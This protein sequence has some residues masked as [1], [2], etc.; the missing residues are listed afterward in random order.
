MESLVSADWAVS[1]LL[2]ETFVELR[3]SYPPAAAPNERWVNGELIEVEQGWAAE[4]AILAFPSI[5]HGRLPLMARHL[6][7]RASRSVP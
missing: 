7:T 4:M 2:R 5:S 6:S 1:N 3:L